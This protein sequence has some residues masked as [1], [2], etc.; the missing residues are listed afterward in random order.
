MEVVF[1]N[2][3]QARLDLVLQLIWWVG[4]GLSSALFVA[5]LAVPPAEKEENAPKPR[6]SKLV[7]GVLT[8]VV[9]TTVSSALGWLVFGERI[10]RREIEELPSVVATVKSVDTQNSFHSHVV[11]IYLRVDDETVS[12]RAEYVIPDSQFPSTPGQRLSIPLALERLTPG[13]SVTL[14]KFR[15]RDGSSIRVLLFLNPK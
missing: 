12:G 7:A 3:I 10:V 11:T 13:S 1:E 14:R 9:V 2:P 4:L 15:A 6:L 5:A 8:L